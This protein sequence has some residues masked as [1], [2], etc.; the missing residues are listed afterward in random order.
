MKRGEKPSRKCR[1]VQTSIYKIRFSFSSESLPPS[2]FLCFLG[3][4]HF[5]STVSSRPVAKNKNFSIS[6]TVSLA[7]PLTVTC[8]LDLF[9]KMN[10]EKLD[11]NKGCGRTM[12]CLVQ[13]QI[14]NR[15]EI[16]G[17]TSW[18]GQDKDVPYT[19]RI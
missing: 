12:Q 9:L 3:L 10:K 19:D 2:F 16:G 14:P 5:H 7:S 8:N 18:R 11:K 6:H 1:K 13:V 17:S 4:K 15:A